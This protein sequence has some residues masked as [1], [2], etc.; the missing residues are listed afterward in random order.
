MQGQIYSGR[1]AEVVIQYKKSKGAGI[2]RN[3]YRRATPSERQD[4]YHRGSCQRV[5]RMVCLIPLPHRLIP[6]KPP[7]SAADVRVLEVCRVLRNPP[8]PQARRVAPLVRALRLPRPL[9][10]PRALLVRHH[11]RLPVLPQERLVA[12][13]EGARVARQA[14]ARPH[15]RRAGVRPVVAR[16]DAAAVEVLGAVRRGGRPLADEYPEVERGELGRVP[17]RGGDV[18]LV[19][20]LDV[21]LREHL[22]DVRVHPDALPAWGRL[23]AV[24]VAVGLRREG[25]AG[26]VH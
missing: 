12:R 4:I 19:R 18:L 9:Q 21:C 7:P 5:K 22:V 6:S 10:P 2:E 15:G 3:R 25:G 14:R 17:A 1:T 20:E 26:H 23:E 24:P 8:A 16:A 11:L 13:A